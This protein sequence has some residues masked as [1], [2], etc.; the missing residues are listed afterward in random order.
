MLLTVSS[1]SAVVAAAAEDD[2]GAS[3]VATAFCCNI[4]CLVNT[5]QYKAVK[6]KMRKASHA[7]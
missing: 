6:P 5:H 7:Q 4:C 1:T 3:D 2:E